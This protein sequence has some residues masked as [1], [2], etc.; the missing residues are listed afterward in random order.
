MAAATSSICCDCCWLWFWLSAAISPSDF[1]AWSRLS[2][3]C[4]DW[5]ITPRSLL[6]NTLK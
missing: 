4:M 3:D 6:V 5:L 1:D 2:A